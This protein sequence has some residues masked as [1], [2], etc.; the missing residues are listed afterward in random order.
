MGVRV[1]SGRSYVLKLHE[2]EL[3]SGVAGWDS[4]CVAGRV[5]DL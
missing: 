1:G 3:V 4:I 5:Y 2:S